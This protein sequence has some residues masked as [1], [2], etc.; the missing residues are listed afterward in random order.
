AVGIHSGDLPKRS[1]EIWDIPSKKLIRTFD[2][3]AAAL[4]GIASSPD[5]KFLA[6]ADFQQSL[7]ITTVPM[8]NGGLEGSIR[9][10]ADDDD[11]VSVAVWDIA[12]GKRSGLFGAETGARSLAYSPDGKYLATAGPN[13]V[14]IYDNA[15]GT[16]LEVGRID[17]VTAVDAI[18]FSPDSRAIVLAQEAEPL[19]SSQ[20]GGIGKLT[21]S[22]T[23]GFL[24][25]YKGLPSLP[26][27]TMVDNATRKSDR[28]LTGGSK[29]EI[30]QLTP[31][32]APREQ[33][34]WEAVLLWAKNRPD[35][36][37]KILQ[38]VIAG[39]PSYGEALRLNTL[40]F[41]MKSPDNALALLTAATKADP[42][43]VS[44]WRSL[45]DLQYALKKYPES[46]ASYEQ[47]LKLRPEYGL[48]AGHEAGAWGAL[49]M[50]LESSENTQATMDEAVKAFTKAIQLR[51]GVA[52][53]YANIGSA[54]Y[55]RSDFDTALQFDEIARKLRPD[56]SRIYYN[57]GHTYK[58]K[59]NKQHAIEAYT[60]YVL[61]GEPGEEARV[62]N[63][64]QLILELRKQ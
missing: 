17:T 2:E 23:V 11:A 24:M 58:A 42:A 32:A 8:A 63:A 61:M 49:G 45:G 56:H 5:H 16:L 31:Q 46:I 47:A 3:G 52:Q 26:G 29:I 35:D 53:F 20:P 6:I 10:L 1:A 43:C 59:G 60:R 37:K 55:F 15:S 13:G 19:V 39:N 18:S 38:E 25:P 30:W 48:V 4:R 40:L 44:C 21:D 36:A 14:V 54:L 62:A 57:L 22:A 12:S 41:E 34:L 28:S 27:A 9:L 7:L 64:K 33:R 51:P 50:M